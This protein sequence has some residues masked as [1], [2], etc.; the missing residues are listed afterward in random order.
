M[1]SSDKRFSDLFKETLKIKKI[2]IATQTSKNFFN[3]E[4]KQKSAK[5]VISYPLNPRQSVNLAKML[6]QKING[7]TTKPVKT[8]KYDLKI[9]G[10]L[11]NK[12]N[13]AI[14][15]VLQEALIIIK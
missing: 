13:K 1:L 7:S 14:T 8:N 2:P 5:I 11:T 4:L 15:E 10:K 3:I 12:I 6:Q 9:E